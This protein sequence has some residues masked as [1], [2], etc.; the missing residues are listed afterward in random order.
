LLGLTT[1]GGAG[2]GQGMAA[3]V[4]AI[5]AVAQGNEEAR[6]VIAPLIA[7]MQDDK[8]TRKLR[9]LLELILDQAYNPL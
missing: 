9:M 1:Q 8:N 7:Q 4:G 5:V 3:F 6:S 2:E